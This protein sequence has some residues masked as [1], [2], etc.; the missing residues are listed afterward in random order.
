MSEPRPRIYLVSDLHL[1]A[2][3]P[4]ASLIREKFFVR[5]LREVAA[6]ATD[7]YLVGD[8]F[9]FWFEYR[10]A[11]PRGYIRLLGT[12]AELADRGVRIHWFVGNHDL[13]IHDYLPEQFQ[14]HI[15]RTPVVHTWFGKSYYIAHGDGLG[16]GDH[17]YKLMKKVVTHPLS[18]WLFA[19]IHPNTGIGAAL[20]IS[21]RGGN[22]VYSKPDKSH[23]HRGSGEYL[24]A[25]AQVVWQ[26][27]QDLEA[28][29]FGHRHLAIDDQLRDG[30]RI[31]ILGDWISYFSYIEITEA[32]PDLKLF[33]PALLGQ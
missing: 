22:Q 30:P 16:P 19:R 7:L 9:D 6:D 32:G 14:V 29:I 25:H 10:Q 13:W 26:Q 17:G 1:G 24:Y 2:P 3:S 31:M 28:F 27:R 8:V 23:P 12:L 5:W 33:L 20:Y 21:N 15:Y 18:Q 4:E 11:V